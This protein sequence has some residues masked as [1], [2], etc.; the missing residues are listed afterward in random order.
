MIICSM[1]LKTL[2]KQKGIKPFHLSKSLEIPVSS[3]HYHLVYGA[4][5]NP[6]YAQKIVTCY[7]GEI[8]LED[9][10]FQKKMKK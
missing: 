10:I 2:L 3:L 6:K 1:T 4:P 5:L 9:M 7:P 8:K